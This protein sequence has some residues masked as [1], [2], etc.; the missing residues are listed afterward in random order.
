MAAFYGMVPSNEVIYKAKEAAEKAIS[1]DP[2][3]CEPYCSLGCYYTCFGWDWELARKNFLKSIELNPNYTQA[4]YWYG[5]LY[6]AWGKGD[7]KQAE[8]YGKQAT[9]VEP[10]SSIC[11]GLELPGT[12]AIQGSYSNI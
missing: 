10:L 3:L 2:T 8:K 6:L 4:L 12:E 1:L 7:F 5:S 11:H 9:K